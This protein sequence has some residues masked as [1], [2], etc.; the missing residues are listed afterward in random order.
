MGVFCEEWED[1]GGEDG[2]VRVLRRGRMWVGR[3]VNVV[4]EN[5]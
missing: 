5:G 1:E 2:V 3:R 4:E